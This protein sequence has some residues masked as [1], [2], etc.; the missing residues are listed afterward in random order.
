MTPS[1]APIAVSIWN[2]SGLDLSDG[3]TVLRLRISGSPSTPPR[4]SSSAAIA[5]RSNQIVFVLK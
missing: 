4:A 2:T 3:S 1:A 5:R